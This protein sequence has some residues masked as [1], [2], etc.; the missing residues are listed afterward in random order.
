MANPGSITPTDLTELLRSARAARGASSRGRPRGGGAPPGAAAGRGSS[1]TA[2]VPSPQSPDIAI[3]RTDDDASISRLSAV[4]LGYLSDPF[5]RLFVPQGAPPQRRFPIINRGTFVRT[6]CID[7]LVNLFL[8]SPSNS[9]EPKQ[10]LSLGAGTDTRYF[11]LRNANPSLP[12]L[13]HEIDFPPITASKIATI[14]RHPTLSSLIPTPSIPTP[15]ALQS[16]TLNIHPLV[17]SSLPS[18][19][20]LPNFSSTAPTLIL[21]ECCLC[22]LPPTLT[23][24]LT[25]HILNSLLQSTT[26]A[27]LILYEPT[28]PHTAFGRVMAENLSRRGVSMPGL[29]KWDSP[30]AQARRLKDAGFNDVGVVSVREAWEE[31]VDEGEKERVGGLEMLDEV[32]EWDLLGGHYIIGWGSR[33]DGWDGMKGLQSSEPDPR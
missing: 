30:A 4:E 9:S 1:S 8:T 26:P 12:L 7:K 10:I 13:Y 33:G 28:L 25:T 20:S 6:D 19:Q 2:P 21:S 32:E 17:L 11:R 5:A 15:S 16:S 3:Q 24:S 23:I 27:G 22:Y 29:E 31:W 18:T 14:T